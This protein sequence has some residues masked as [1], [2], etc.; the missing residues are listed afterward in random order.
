MACILTVPSEVTFQL[1]CTGTRAAGK[2]SCLAVGGFHV[3]SQARL[4]AEGPFTQSA[5]PNIGVTFNMLSVGL[6]A[7][8]YLPTN[9]TNQF[10][11][12]I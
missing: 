11:I 5:G 8:V 4:P 9:A 10:F 7:A 6:R 2:S 12:R 1:E 3:A